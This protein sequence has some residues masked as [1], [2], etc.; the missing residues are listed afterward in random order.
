[1]RIVIFFEKLCY[2]EHAVEAGRT[3]RLNPERGEAYDNTRAYRFDYNDSVDCRC[4]EKKIT[5]S[6]CLIGKRGY[7]VIIG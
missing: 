6:L 3:W 4:H 5:A 2:N 1:M 7:V